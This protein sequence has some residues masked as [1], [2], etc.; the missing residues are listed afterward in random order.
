[1]NI[2]GGSGETKSLSFDTLI[3]R[4]LAKKIAPILNYFKN[5]QHIQ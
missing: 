3:S 1:M 4:P 5:I 2:I